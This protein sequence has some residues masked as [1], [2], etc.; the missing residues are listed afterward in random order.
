MAVTKAE[1]K[2]VQKGIGKHLDTNRK[3]A[4]KART[5]VVRERD[6]E[7]YLVELV[8]AHH[9]EVRKLKW[10]GRRGA[11]D[12]AVFLNGF[13]LVE[14]KAP[15]EGLRPEQKREQARLRAVGVE[16]RVLD[17]YDRVRLFIHAAVLRTL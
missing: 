14:L 15:G 8:K 9:G 2:A 12:R 6:V 17:S 11:P 4:A 10:I 5:K 3:T 7:K 1:I 13:H 16:V